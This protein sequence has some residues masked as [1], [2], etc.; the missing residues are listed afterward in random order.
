MV[1]L[2]QTNRDV[3]GGKIG[4]MAKTSNKTADNAQRGDAPMLTEE[5]VA[6]LRN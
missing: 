6:T 4:E 2:S 3:I 5:I 1:A